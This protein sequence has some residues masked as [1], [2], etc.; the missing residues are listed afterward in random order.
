MNAKNSRGGR[1]EIVSL[2]TSADRLD[3]RGPFDFAQGRLP[4]AT[5]TLRENFSEFAPQDFAGGGAGDGVDE[6]DFAGLF[7]VGEAV[8]YEAA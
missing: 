4:V 8:G 1:R 6:V 3:G 5:H 2:I 7:V